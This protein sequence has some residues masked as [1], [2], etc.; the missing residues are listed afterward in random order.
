MDQDQQLTLYCLYKQGTVGDVNIAKPWMIDVVGKK[1]WEAW[2]SVKGFPKNS[3]KLAYIFIVEQL[4]NGGSLCNISGNFDNG[5][6]DPIGMG[7]V[8]STLK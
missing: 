5:T 1:K 3:A 4:M 6:P 7:V 2:N 8:V